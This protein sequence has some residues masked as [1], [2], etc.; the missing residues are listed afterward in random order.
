MTV[1]QRLAKLEADL[2]QGISRR[3]QEALSKLSLAELDE[4]IILA[5]QFSE[6]RVPDPLLL[7]KYMS[8]LDF[9]IADIEN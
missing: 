9:P 6:D 5:T 7:E 4:L 8:L 2:S 1:S 3:R